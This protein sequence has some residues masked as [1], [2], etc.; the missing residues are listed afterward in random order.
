MAYEEY[1]DRLDKM[2]SGQYFASAG[3]PETGVNFASNLPNDQ[4]AEVLQQTGLGDSQPGKPFSEVP[5]TNNMYRAPTMTSAQSALADRANAVNVPQRGGIDQ[6]GNILGRYSDA[7]GK[8]QQR[9]FSPVQEAR[10]QAGMMT[11]GGF[12]SAGKRALTD[13]LTQDYRR[14]GAAGAPVGE[15]QHERDM[16]RRNAAPDGPDAKKAEAE[17]RVGAAEKMAAGNVDAAK[18]KAT[19]DVTVAETQAQGEMDK[20]VAQG[21]VP[22]TPQSDAA[23]KK[24]QDELVASG[25]TA[26]ALEMQKKQ[27]EAEFNMRYGNTKTT[28]TDDETGTTTVTEDTFE[29]PKPSLEGQTMNDISATGF[30]AGENRSGK[31]SALLGPDNRINTEAEKKLADRIISE[32]NDYAAQAQK[33]PNPAN[34]AGYE[35]WLTTPD[36]LLYQSLAAIEK[37]KYKELALRLSGQSQ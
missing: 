3:T 28:K 31:L 37:K 14:F 25:Q 29:R 5:V 9:A 22:G 17:G 2:K 32:G 6:Q 18:A 23:M 10:K 13:A 7:E 20:L 35:R 1:L 27:A 11:S 33:S 16:A 30:G 12:T 8:V 26:L 34:K 21:L 24:K 36:G 15:V 19:G 4:K